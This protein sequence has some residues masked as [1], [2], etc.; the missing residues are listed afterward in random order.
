MDAFL[1]LFLEFLNLFPNL[2][3]PLL[4]RM[5]KLSEALRVCLLNLLAQPETLDQIEADNADD[6]NNQQVERDVLHIADDTRNR[7]AEE[8]PDAGESRNP[9]RAT[10]NR[11]EHEA[12]DGHPPHPVKD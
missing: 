9:G 4:R 12:Q 6:E 3:K 7:A 8:I 10:R 5:L 1:D 11:Q 2:L